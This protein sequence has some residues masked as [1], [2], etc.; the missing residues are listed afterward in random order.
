M[1]DFAAAQAELRGLVA[2]LPQSWLAHHDH[3]NAL[4]DLGRFTEAEAAYRAALAI[5][6]TP[7][8]LNHLAAVLRDLGRL[9]EA[10]KAAERGLALAPAI[11]ISPTIWR[12]R[13]L[14]A[15]NLREGFTLYEVR[16]AKYGAVA[17]PGRAWTG[18]ALAGRTILV[19]AEQGLGD[20]I[21][22]LRY[23]PA[24]ARRGARVV[25]RV[26][27]PWSGS[28]RPPPV[29]KVAIDQA[30]PLPPYDF[31]APLMSLPHLLGCDEP[32]PVPSP[33]LAADAQGVRTWRHRLA[34]LPGLKIGLV[35]AGNAGFAADHL[36]SIPA[37]AL[38]PL[39]RS[40]A[41]ISSAC[42]RARETDRPC[43]CTTGRKSWAT[44]RQLRPWS[45]PLIWSWR[46]IPR[47]PTSPARWASR[48]AAEQGRCVLALGRGGEDCLWYPSLRQFRQ[49]VPGEWD[50]PVRRLVTALEDLAIGA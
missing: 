8:A 17:L 25:L 20:T 32:C 36:R 43:P 37:Q 18:Q 33:Y 10:R 3:G 30:A 39:A 7:L 11:A 42:R 24:L 40:T 41:C 26:P 1:R 9:E 15:G 35:W 31:H 22:F 45:K 21:Q 49:D 27:A 4:R 29:S 44:W 34:A 47:S 38:A 19:A 6:E 12:S 16:A 50:A 14:T 5:A 48:L 2:A 13:S 23:L 28:W 46:S